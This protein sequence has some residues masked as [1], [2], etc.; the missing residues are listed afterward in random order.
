MEAG[1]NSPFSC[2]C[3]WVFSL[4]LSLPT[5]RLWRLAVILPSHVHVS[6]FSV[7]LSLCAHSKIMEAGCNSPF[8]CTCVSFLSV[9]L[10]AH[11]KIMEAG[12]NSPFSCTCVWVFCLSLSAHSK[13]MEA[14]C[15]SPFSCTCVWV[16]CLSLSAHSKIMEAGCNSPFSCTCVWV[17]CLSL[18]LPTAR[19]WRLPVTVNPLSHVHVSAKRFLSIK[20]KKKRNNDVLWSWSR[21]L[22]GRQDAAKSGVPVSCQLVIHLFVP[23]PSHPGQRTGKLT[24]FD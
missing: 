22:F 12:C 17:F 13:I 14:G 2:T 7:S 11:S 21:V 10:S 6:E 3:V 5:A 15:N 4:S 9:S 16:F 18:S 23:S 8:S 1:C 20:K 19:L 24:L